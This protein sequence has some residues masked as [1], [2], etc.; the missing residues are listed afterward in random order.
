MNNI[1]VT[2][3]NG[4]LGTNLSHELLHQGY[5]VKGLV[6]KLSSY[7]GNTHK[8]LQLIQGTL[9]DNFVDQLEHID[10][11]IHA[12]A[13]TDQSLYNY[14]SYWQINYN[15]TIQLFHAAIKAKVKKF[16]FVSTANTIGY[17][18]KETSG[19]EKYTIKAP[20]NTSFYAKSK[21]EAEHYLLQHNHDIEV[22]IINPTFMLGPYDTKPSSGKII[23]MGWKK[24]IIF[25]PPG[26][27][28]FVHVK[29]VA[30]GIIK[31]IIKGKNGEKYLIA[32]KNLTYQ[33]FFKRINT[34]A[35]QKPILIPIPKRC[36]YLAGIIGDLLRLLKINT[37]LSSNNMK[38]LCIHNYFSN[39]KS[40]QQLDMTYL[41]ID[42]AILDAIQYFSIT[43][44][45][46]A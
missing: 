13:V 26:G 36:F 37:N 32:N 23:F 40:V 10:C 6:R 41:S 11:V 8:N 4:L 45:K 19:N 31:S 22:I 15:A 9:F 34:L 42:T 2:G 30:K 29:D 7:K 46:K 20:F 38:A 24:R 39:T 3:I 33:E 12:A 1:F 35:F 25:Y 18:T 17:G 5:H 28:N 21:L 44:R 16:I 43:K 14:D 27:K